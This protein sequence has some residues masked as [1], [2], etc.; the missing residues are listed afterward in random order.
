MFDGELRELGGCPKTQLL[1]DT[2]LVKFHGSRRQIQNC[3]SLLGRTSF[4]QKLQDLTLPR[5]E[6]R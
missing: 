2:V 1:H 5:R 3:C 4:S 6:P